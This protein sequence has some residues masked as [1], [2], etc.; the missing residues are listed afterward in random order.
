MHA[1]AHRRLTNAGVGMISQKDMAI[2]QF[3]F[4]GFQLLMP[5]EFGI[6]GSEE[7]LEA[8]SHLWRVIGFMLGTD[9]RFNCC[10]ETLSET[11][12]R[13]RAIRDEMLLPAMQSP[14]PE[15][16]DYIR[17][18]YDGMWY[19]DPS[20]HY[21]KERARVGDVYFQTRR[22]FSKLRCVWQLNEVFNY[23]NKHFD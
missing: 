12:K 8:F 9:D 3:M 14:F 19:F 17:I 16:N 23:S 1:V 2:T 15:Y 7:Q 13:L 5:S 18:A 4:A 20:L 6:V 22:L 10:G 11:R 21:G